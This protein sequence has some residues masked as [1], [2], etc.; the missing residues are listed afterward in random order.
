MEFEEVVRS[1]H[2]VRNFTTAAVADQLVLELLD[3]AR[4]APSA[5][6]TQGTEFL[7]IGADHTARFW[8]LT[9]APERRAGF[10]WPGLLSAPVL[11]LPLASRAAY[12]QRYSEPDK[13]GSLYGADPASWQVPFWDV[14]CAFATMSL[15]LAAHDRGLGA[16]FFALARGR[17]E[18]LEEFE[19]P[20]E[21][22]PIGVVALGWPAPHRRSSSAQRGRRAT[23][24]LVHWGRYGERR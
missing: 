5:G 18:V 14:D 19:I 16:L 20:P 1:R 24:E 10:P 13:A 8:E 11:V 6:H 3:L 4:R 7:V 17:A 21:F 22:Q 23:S 15:L 9:L 12:L 2:M